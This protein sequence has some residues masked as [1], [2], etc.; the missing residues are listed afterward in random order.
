[1]IIK[2]ILIFIAGFVVDLLATKYTSYVAE[3]RIAKASLISGLIT[4]VNFVFLTVILQDATN[5]GIF[6]ILAFASGSSIGT[7]IAMKKV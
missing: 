1:M 3:K 5:S 7:F 6:N 4:I 2:I